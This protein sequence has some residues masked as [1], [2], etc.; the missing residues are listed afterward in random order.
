MVAQE[1]SPCPRMNPSDD[2]PPR[3]EARALAFSRQDEAIFGPMSLVVRAGEV[4]LIEGGNGSGKTTLLRVLAGLLEASAGT[5]TREAQPFGEEP[6]T[7]VVFL[8]HQGGLKLDLSARENLGF[9]K[10]LTGLRQGS[11]IA[12]V[13]KSVGLEGFEDTPLR[14]LSAG[15]KKRAA[16][17]AIL[18]APVSLWLLDEPY[19]NLDREGHR[20]VDRMLETHIARGG[21]AVITAHGML[22]PAVSRLRRQP[23]ECAHG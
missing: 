3:I 23:M 22:D 13:L 12:G 15:Q 9:T 14:F 19:A 11:S 5:V 6:S 8:G 1:L 2:T 4:L 7:P 16:L 17:A 18:I 10:Q 21:A 20:L